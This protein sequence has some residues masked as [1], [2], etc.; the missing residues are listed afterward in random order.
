MKAVLCWVLCVALSSVATAAP[1]C[2]PP[3]GSAVCLR[4]GLAPALAHDSG[5]WGYVAQD[6]RWMIMAQFDAVQPFFEGLAGVYQGDKAGYINRLGQMTISPS[7]D[8]VADFKNSTAA[9]V[10]DGKLGYIRL[11]G[12]SLISPQFTPPELDRQALHRHNPLN[13]YNFFDGLAITQQG[14]RFGYI[15]TQGRLAIPHRYEQA[16][17][18]L[19][20]L[21]KVVIDGRLGFIDKQGNLVIHPEF[22]APQRTGDRSSSDGLDSLLS[23]FNHGAATVQ[24]NGDYGV[25]NPQGMPIVPFGQYGYIGQFVDAV[26]VIATH[27]GKYGYIS[28]TGEVLLEPQY[29][30]AY[31]FVNGTGVVE[32]WQTEERF[33]VDKR[34]RRQS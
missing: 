8:A 1:Y 17:V 18:F 9:V 26:A 21:A 33:R 19:N 34:A 24:K 32:S 10:K 4:Q 7:F 29:D 15:N 20:G 30:M 31:D 14:G 22:D 11:D 6:G 16:G 27:H 25:I 2:T 3:P 23:G 13:L 28:H 5:R 12:K